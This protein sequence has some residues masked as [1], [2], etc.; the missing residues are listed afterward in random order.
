MAK[1]NL[2]SAAFLLPE[3]IDPLIAIRE[4]VQNAI[5]GGAT[6]V[7]IEEHPSGGILIRDNGKGMTPKE[8]RL[9]LTGLGSSSS[10]LGRGAAQ[11]MGIGSKIASALCGPAVFTSHCQR[12]P[13]NNQA[14]QIIL[15]ATDDG[16]HFEGLPDTEHGVGKFV[17]IPRD[18]LDKRSGTSVHL[19]SANFS[20][21]KIIEFLNQRYLSIPGEVVVTAVDRSSEIR[22]VGALG[23]LKALC[24]VNGTKA[25]KG[26]T[27]CPAFNLHWGIR[28]Q[29]AS[30]RQSELV[31]P[32]SA[33]PFSFAADGECVEWWDS[34]RG[35]IA[36]VNTAG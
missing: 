20:I 19:K 13:E 1:L 22:I 23:S 4:M 9:Y 8:M 6:C 33:P 17:S 27:T 29:K 35:G 36:K 2:V 21:T 25:Y 31:S 7:R 11:R 26:T 16:T 24:E 18:S 3:D 15:K 32:W 5:D 10:K 12:S 14:Y 28:P 30:R 34:H